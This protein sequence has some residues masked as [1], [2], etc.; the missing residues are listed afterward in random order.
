[1]AYSSVEKIWFLMFLGALRV[2]RACPD[3]K[4]RRLIGSL[5]FLL[6]VEF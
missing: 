2:I 1:M 3:T 4:V 6:F 5:L